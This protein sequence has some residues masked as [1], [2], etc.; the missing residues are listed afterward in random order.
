LISASLLVFFLFTGGCHS[1]T[2]L[3]DRNKKDPGVSDFKTETEDGKTKLVGDCA[4]IGNYQSIPVHGFGLVVGLPGTGGEDAN[5]FHYK[6]VY[7]ELNRQK[8][9]GIRTLLAR[10]DTAVV[11]VR[12]LMRPGIQEGERFD[13]QVLL[14]SDTST[15][16]LQG[17]RLTKTKL[18]EMA[19]SQSG[20]LQM[21]APHANVEGPIMVADPMATEVS[22][23]EGLKN[24][25][26]LS[27][28]ITT[29][30]RSLS[31]IMKKDSTDFY[32]VD[33]ITKAI[34]HRFYMPTGSR[35]G[36]ADAAKDSL[37]ILNIHPDYAND[38]DRYVKVIQSIAGFETPT[39]QLQRME[40]LKEEVLFPD[41]AQQAAFQL[42][43][44][45]KAGI[46]ALQRALRSP[47][48]EV[49]FHAATSL[50][51]L[52]D[53]TAAKE[54][55]E[56]ARL[57]PAFRVYA[58]N[59][60]SVMKNDLE[61]EYNLQELLHVPDA[62]TRYGAF[63]ALKTRNPLDPT[64]RGQ[65]LEG[66]F[67]YHGISSQAIPMVHI[68]SQKYPE[69]VLFGTETFLRQPFTLEPGAA[70]YVNGQTPGSVMVTRFALM[71]VDEKRMVSN[72]L[73]EI[74]RAVVDMGG[75]YPDVV[76]MLRQADMQGALP[77]RLEIDCLPE[78]NR[79]YRRQGGSEVELVNDD[80][81]EK[82]KTVWER[83]NPKNLF[84]PNPGEKTSDYTGTVNTSSRD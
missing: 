62:E 70:I 2:D 80:E 46:G 77:C 19:N 74:I 61:A 30:S 32:A 6:W 53:G 71:G 5:T 56:I 10:P 27:G 28:A 55:A 82:P 43:A 75:T 23:P 54:L 8:V 50:A 57:E 25:T 18:F 22:N 52:G 59:A 33:K 39:Q 16:N 68:T 48:M 13:V 9:T 20:D 36:V 3:F 67:S 72:R 58:L 12:G 21:S 51:Y 42:E 81:V 73:D 35:K 76:K 14:P 63:R 17:G 84:S 7:D 45:G 11:E 44:I 4:F 38:I 64:I 29:E 34:N 69:V 47:N 24:G 41:T 66:Q 1:L 26:I 78:P 37:I 15:K 60:L 83:M 79:I 65:M 40:R 31:L 49:R